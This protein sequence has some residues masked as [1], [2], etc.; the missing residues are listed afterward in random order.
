MIQQMAHARAIKKNRERV[1]YAERLVSSYEGI[2][3]EERR[4]TNTLA[5]R[6]RRNTP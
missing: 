5:R 3:G 6:T 1:K 4:R 2:A